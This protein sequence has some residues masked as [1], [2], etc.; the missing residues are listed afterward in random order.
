MDKDSIDIDKYWPQENPSPGLLEFVRGDEFA[1]QCG[2]DQLLPTY[3][4]RY[5]KE[6]HLRQ[7]YRVMLFREASWTLA[8]PLLEQL[9]S[10]T[11]PISAIDQYL[12]VVSRL[13][14]L[15]SIRFLLDA[16]FDY[17][18]SYVWSAPLEEL[19]FPIDDLKN[20]TMHKAIQFVKE[21][22][23]LF[24]DQLVKGVSFADGGFWEDAPQSCPGDIQLEVSRW[25]PPL[26]DVLTVTDEN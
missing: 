26:G 19:M 4:G 8:E 1:R 23:E 24:P 21:H 12:G 11:I 16:F 10:L 18:A 7:F 6:Q 5:E 25:L 3:Y 2:L 15:E 14:Q 22:A 13:G 17:K 20:Q 9:Q